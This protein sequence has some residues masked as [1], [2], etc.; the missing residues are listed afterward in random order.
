MKKHYGKI[1]LAVQLGAG[2]LLIAG[3]LG[4]LPVTLLIIMVSTVLAGPLFCG[5]VCPFGTLQDLVSKLTHK[6][7]KRQMPKGLQKVLAVSR[8]LLLGATTLLTLDFVFALMQYDA[9]INFLS[10]LS[11]KALT[12]GAY[13]VLGAYLL[14]AVFF[15]RPFCSYMCPQGA[16]YGLMSSLRPFRIVRN[17]DAC[18]NCG[19]CNRVCPMHID[20]TGSENV[21][22]LQCINC[23]NCVAACPKKG[24]LKFGILKLSA[25]KAG[26][27]LAAVAIVVA[28]G[29]GFAAYQLT[30]DQAAQQSAEAQALVELQNQDTATESDQAAQATASNLP[31]TPTATT[32]SAAP[33][34]TSE[35]ITPA[36]TA[37]AE[38]APVT[39]TGEAAGIADGTYTGEA[40]GFRGP[41]TVA[42]TVKDQ[43]IVSVE[44]VSN[45]DDRKWFNRAVNKIPDWIVSAQSTDVDTVS[46]ATYSSLGII[47]AA[48]NALNSAK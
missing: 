47:N 45:V 10:V 39:P 2:A 14:I 6:I 43:Q 25:K 40:N 12:V 34:S 4:N 33:S 15:E 46:G 42:V 3:G 36:A 35:T 17:A 22:S 19:K 41:M 26:I 23:M 8:Y 30:A 7:K 24:A 20:I 27:Y 48:K 38:S 16:Q 37:T 9:H 1:R 5:W 11:G 13:A 28:G 18:V 31:A 21:T 29:T 44:V 32:S